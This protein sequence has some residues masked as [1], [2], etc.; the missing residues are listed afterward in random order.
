MNKSIKKKKKEDLKPGCPHLECDISLA[1]ME[2]W[3]DGRTWIELTFTLQAHWLYKLR[4]FV[5]LGINNKT[6]K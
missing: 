6:K 5:K 1:Y 2:G 3:A 4:W